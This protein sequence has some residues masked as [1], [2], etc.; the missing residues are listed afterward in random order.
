MGTTGALLHLSH[1]R[2]EQ[3]GIT[4]A[5]VVESIERLARGRA[6]G[7][8]WHT[9]KASLH[10][11]DGR[12]MMSTMAAATD[13]PFMAVKSLLLNPLNP[14]Q[15]I[16]AINALIAVHDARTGIPVAVVDGNWIT[17]VRTAGLSA[18]AAKRLAR[19]DSAVAAFVGCGVQATSHLRAFADLFPL[20]EIRT[21]GRGR[22]SRD[23]LCG[24]ARDL[25]LR[26][27]ACE[28]PEAAL[29]GADLAITT[30]PLTGELDPFL[31]ARWLPA[32]AFAAIVDLGR[33]WHG[34]TLGAFDRIVIDDCEQE[35]RMARPMVDPAMVDGDLF[36]LVDGT[37]PPRDDGEQRTAFVF[38]G[39]ALGD[40]AVAGLA[41]QRALEAGA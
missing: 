25:G 6:A 5:D 21:L 16:A 19:P 2:L 40:L 27:V 18:V 11:P 36:G 24:L 33:P 20:R 41:C 10:L 29:E 8:F 32:G 9:P 13:P 14:E 1:E 3:L 28:E 22:A 15:G 39:M 34:D 37:V 26:A 7:T 17:A 30:V 4:T 23:A 35:A 12:Y 38:R 31:D